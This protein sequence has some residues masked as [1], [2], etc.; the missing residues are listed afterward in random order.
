MKTMELIEETFD[1]FEK[2]F[3]KQEFKE[4][5]NEEFK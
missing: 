4:K 1:Q 3:K 5:K 2:F